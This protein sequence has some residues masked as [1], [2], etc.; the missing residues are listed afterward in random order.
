MGD[1]KGLLHI[2]VANFQVGAVHLLFHAL[3]IAPDKL[4]DSV[5]LAVVLLELL[6]VAEKLRVEVLLLLKK[7][8]ELGLNRNEDFADTFRVVVDGVEV[9]LYGLGDSEELVDILAGTEV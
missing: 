2:G 9:A 8:V 4:E 3:V 7:T 6:D 1:A 5:E